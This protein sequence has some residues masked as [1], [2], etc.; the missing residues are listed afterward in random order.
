VTILAGTRL[1]VAWDLGN[2][3]WNFTFRIAIC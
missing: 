1:E 3:A 2:S